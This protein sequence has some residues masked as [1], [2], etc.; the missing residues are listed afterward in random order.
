MH[1]YSL[2]DNP[3]KFHPDRISMTE[4]QAFPRGRPNNKKKHN[5]NKMSSD[6]GSVPDPEIGRCRAD[7]TNKI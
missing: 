5:Q 4:P 6:M 1:A 7:L 3:A 2:E